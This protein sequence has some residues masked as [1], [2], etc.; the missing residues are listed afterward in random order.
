[1]DLH[2]NLFY[3]YRGPIANDVDRDRQ[4]EN[5]LTKALIN[6]LELG[7]ERVWRPFLAE[8]GLSSV[9][10]GFLLQRN[11][12]PG[13]AGHKRHRLLLGISNQKSRWSLDVN[14]K[15]KQESIPDA[16]VY[17]DGFA[18]LVES[19]V[20]SDFSAGQMQAH[21]ARLNSLEG[22]PPVVRLMTWKQLHRLFNSFLPSLKKTASRQHLLVQQ[23]I[24]FLEYSGMSGFTG[25][26]REHFDYFVLHDDDDARRW[27]LEQVKDLASH[28][29]ALLHK[30]A[31]FY[32]AYDI[33]TLK[34]SDLKCWFAFGPRGTYRN[35]THQTL[36]LD[37]NGLTIFVNAELKAATDRLKAVV[38]KS[39]QALRKA[40]QDLDKGGQYE[41]VL[42]KR[43]QRQ[44]S[45]YDYT[46]QMRLHSSMLTDRKTREVA[47]N[48]FSQ[49]IQQLDLFELS[50]ERLVPPA[51]LLELS[52][53]DPP[54]VIPYIVDILKRNHALVKLL[55]E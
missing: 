11:D 36:S 12:V 48:A 9:P 28:V 34:R 8:L 18:I 14:A 21:H 52:K 1:M 22:E 42:Q 19:K 32:E 25:F 3:S 24:E 45:V 33:G 29:Q 41:L 51:K 43:T 55:N 6:T 2:H 50:I 39:G 47:W 37:A 49:T 31:T 27:I 16:W 7:D 17:G 15:S 35:V 46:A 30:F 38:R 13:G 44:A 4:L 53:S 26:R 5:N 10:R 20:N 40:L 23:F 54:K